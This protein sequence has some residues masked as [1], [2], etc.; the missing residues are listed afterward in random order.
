MDFDPIK[1][2]GEP[3][4]MDEYDSYAVKVYDLFQS[5]A[6]AAAIAIYLSGLQSELTAKAVEPEH[7]TPLAEKIWRT[8]HR[9]F[10]P[11]EDSA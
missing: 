11:S 1:M 4:A 2:F 3:G 7:L 10:D 6:D 9:S 5:G 8:C